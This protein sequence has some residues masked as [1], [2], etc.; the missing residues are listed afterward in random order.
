MIRAYQSSDLQALREIHGRQ[1]FRYDFPDL[2]NPNFVVRLISAGDDGRARMALL[3]HRTIEAYMLVAPGGRPQEK[4]DEFVELHN[5]ACDA[6]AA[7]GYEDAQAFLPPEIE[8]RFG[9]RL[10]QLGWSQYVGPE[11]RAYSREL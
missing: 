9:K 5:A 10:A 4:F 8:R 7:L 1:G 11:W 6:G 2:E 3:G